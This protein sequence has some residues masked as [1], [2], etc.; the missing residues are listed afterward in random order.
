MP[1]SPSGA[2]GS[3]TKCGMRVAPDARYCQ[4]CGSPLSAAGTPDDKEHT[5]PGKGFESKSRLSTLESQLEELIQL[6][7]QNSTDL[8]KRSS[9]HIDRLIDYYPTYYVTFAG[10]IQS[11]IFGFLLLAILDQMSEFNNGTFDPIWLILIFAL[12]FFNDFYLDSLYKTRGGLPNCSPDPGRYHS[13]LFW[14]DPGPCS[15][16]HQP[17]GDLLVLF[18]AE[19]HCRCRIHPVGPRVPS[20]TAALREESNYTGAIRELGQASQTHGRYPGTNIRCLRRRRSTDPSPFPPSGGHHPGHER[21]PARFPPHQ[22]QKIVGV[23][24]PWGSTHPSGG[25]DPGDSSITLTA[26]FPTG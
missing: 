10:I 24:V 3:C 2:D 17:E 25:R 15:I 11:L 5:R 1:K 14:R 7:S 18:L 20:G 23:V 21:L 6:I 19:C 16:Q 8:F 4:N 13:L 26:L 22:L 12:M 9:S